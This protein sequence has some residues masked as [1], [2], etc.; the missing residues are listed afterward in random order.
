MINTL[1]VSTTA[2][3]EM[4]KLGCVFTRLIIK[5]ER[6]FK[7]TPKIKINNKIYLRNEYIKV[8]ILVI[9]FKINKN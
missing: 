1:P 5:N 3:I 7:I 4:K 6:L 9:F 2:K 8:S